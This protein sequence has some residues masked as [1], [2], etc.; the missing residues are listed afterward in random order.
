ME[1]II[2]DDLRKLV[3]DRL[4][5]IEALTGVEVLFWSL[6]GSMDV[7]IYRYNSDIDVVFVFRSET[8][9]IRAIHD[10][11]GHGLDLWGWI[12]DDVYSTV[13]YCESTSFNQLIECQCS[14]SAEHKRGSLSY[15]FGL[16]VCLGNP[17]CIDRK[18]FFDGH[19]AEFLKRYSPTIVI[20]EMLSRLKAARDKIING[21]NLFGN[22]C[23]YGIWYSLMIRG[24]YENRL[25]GDN[26]I[27]NLLKEYGDNELMDCF[28]SIHNDYKRS[29]YKR[30]QIINNKRVYS[31]I[32]DSYEFGKNTVG[33]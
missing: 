9:R 21:D 11:I 20:I 10:I 19:R 2:P 31:A 28:V 25:P 5:N 8:K 13:D 22:E 17:F 29:A 7:G 24:V 32:I 26:K 14:I 4:K 15:Y 3:E 6:R 33:Y 18:G 16:Y 27:M 12:E 30:A 1:M 23:L